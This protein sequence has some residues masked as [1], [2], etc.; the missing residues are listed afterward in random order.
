MDATSP[1][2]AGHADAPWPDAAALDAVVRSGTRLAAV[3]Q[4]EPWQTAAL[5]GWNALT[6]LAVRLLGVP[7]SFVAVVGPQAD[8]YPSQFGMPASLGS[9]A[10]IVGRSFCH[11]TL[12]LDRMVVIADTHADATLR[13]VPT[14]DSLGVRAYVGVPLHVGAEAIGSFCV[15]D[16]VPRQWDELALATIAQMAAAAERELT[17]HRALSLQAAESARANQLAQQREALVAAVAHDLRTPLQV[18]QLVSRQLQ[19]RLGDGDQVLVGRLLQAA[20]AMRRLADDL[21][22][23]HSLAPDGRAPAR[24][25][26][27]ALFDSA[28]ALMQ[29]IAERAGLRQATGA[30]ADAIVCVDAAELQRVLANLIGNAL[31]YCAADCVVTLSAERAGDEVL[32]TVADNG[33]GMSP[34][35]IAAAF[36]AGWQGADG[37]CRGDGA[38]LGL[39][40]VRTLVQRNGGQVALHST[41]GQGTRVEIRLP[42][43]S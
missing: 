5:E 43:A 16:T 17:L 25:T 35:D 30:V 9:P 2:I 11:Y 10:A 7:A 39:G 4:S 15:I 34:S 41:V 1:H 20:D 40:I 33:P 19:Q 31:K 28:M 12:A 29:P 36:D 23:T 38:G 37:R 8:R 21:V 32:L 42:L 14:V 18:V 3:Q 26:V 27:R 13:A 22:A 24:T 6:Q